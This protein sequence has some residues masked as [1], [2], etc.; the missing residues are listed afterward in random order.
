MNAIVLEQ[1]GT[2]AFGPGVSSRVADDLRQAGARSVLI[3]TT[4][5]VRGS[6]ASGLRMR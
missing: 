6:A 1:V 3:V 4:P 5:S 2:L